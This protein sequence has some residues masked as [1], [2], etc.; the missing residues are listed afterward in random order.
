MTRAIVVFSILLI[1]QVSRGQYVVSTVAGGVPPMTPLSASTASIGDPPRVAVDSAGNLYFGSIHSIFKVDRS[2]ILTRVAGTGRYGYSGDGGAATSAQLAFPDGIA[3]DAAG[4]I[5]VAD[6]DAGVIRKIAANGIISTFAGTGTIGSSGDGGPAAKALFS[7]PTGL[8]FDT[9]GNL[10]IAD[11]GNS[12][13]RMISPDGTIATVAGS[14]ING[15]G[16]NGGPARSADLNAPEGVAVDAAGSIYIA[17][18]FNNVVRKVAPDGTIGLFAGN[19]FPGFSGDNGAASGATLFLPTDVA[20]D[21]LGNVYIADL[22]TIRIRVVTNG[23][24]STIA[25]SAK[26]ILP[27]D[28]MPAVTTRLKGPTGVAVDANGTVYFAE[29]SIGSGSGLNVGDFKVWRVGTDGNISTAAGNG[30]N[31][32]SG[33]NGPAS[34]AQLD[35]PAGMARDSAGNVY[36]ADSANNR[37][38]RISPDGTITTVAG[39]GSP[40]FSGDYGPALNANLNEPMGVAVDA[41][42]DFLYIAD[43]GNNRVRVVNPGGMIYTVAGNGN[44][45]FFGDGSLALNAALRGPRAVMLDPAGNVYI[46]DTLNHRVRKLTLDGILDTVAGRGQ[47]FGGDGG[48]AVTALLNQPS[49][50]ALDVNGNLFIADTANGRIRMVTTGGIITTVAGSDGSNGLGDGGSAT[51]AQLKSPQGVALDAAGNLYVSDTGQNRV[52]K[53]LVDGTISTIGGNGRCCY[54]TDGIPA[55]VA[56]MNAPWGIAV[57][58][59]GNVWVA[60][61]GNHAI[62][63]LQPVRSGGVE[64]VATNSA[65]NLMG[66]IAPGEI[67]T[68]YGSG[69]GPRPAAQYQL[70]SGTQVPT[71]L[72]GVSVLFNGIAGPILYASANQV[73]AIVPY[74]VSGQSVQ[75]TGSYQNAITVSTSVPLAAAAPA[76]FTVDNSGTGQAVAANQDG[77]ANTAKNPAAAGSLITL[78][79]TGEGQTSPNGIEGKPVSVATLP[80]LPVTATIGGLA[81]TV[82]SAAEVVGNVGVMQ[83]TVQIPGGVQ[84]GHA[85]PVVLQVGGISSPAGVTIAVAG[86]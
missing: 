64:G 59:S 40:G 69:L 36:I 37:V 41:S 28:G 24:I 29:G 60:D 63:E 68:I 72:G 35:T 50:V 51:S 12:R 39:N 49:S 2:V 61:S 56:P 70:N 53:V 3:V 27:V 18:T 34:L 8:T 67:V 10:Y 30:L 71:Q 17:D 54:S 22:G 58:P 85:I 1:P 62:R 74:G 83:V 76:L 43:T 52:R 82:Q 21:R 7:G 25:G 16:G 5:F 33:D 19:G 57:D 42:S 31:S 86:I 45:A 9:L 65:S 26:G 14:G 13:I 79:A 32:F 6:R 48:P 75:V 55:A 47:G 44:A 78:Y 38:R 84:P 4:N 11:T 81:A 77:S 20:V 73:T 23:I 80:I 15:S 46:A 66:P